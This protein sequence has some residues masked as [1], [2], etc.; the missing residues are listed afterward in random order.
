MTSYDCGNPIKPIIIFGILF[1]I[2]ILYIL[3]RYRKSHSSES[4]IFQFGIKEKDLGKFVPV[5]QTFIQGLTPLPLKPDCF[6]DITFRPFNVSNPKTDVT[7]YEEGILVRAYKQFYFCP[8]TSCKIEPAKI[9]SEPSTYLF[10]EIQRG[11]DLQEN[12]EKLLAGDYYY[13]YKEVLVG[14]RSGI[15]ADTRHYTK[16]GKLDKRYSKQN[17]NAGGTYSH[18]EYSAT[19]TFYVVSGFA[20][21]VDKGDIQFEIADKQDFL[22]LIKLVYTKAGIPI[23]SFNEMSS[24]EGMVGFQKINVVPLLKEEDRL[25]IKEYLNNPKS[26]ESDDEIII[27]EE[28]LDRIIKDG[29]HTRTVNGVKMGMTREEVRD[30]EIEMR[31]F[32]KEMSEFNEEREGEKLFEGILKARQK[33][34]ALVEEEDIDD[35]DNDDLNIDED[36]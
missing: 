1:I 22:T 26:G 29:N 20:L 23:P 19:E 12:Y 6:S 32:K 30:F 24:Y 21:S 4:R 13:Y 34:L 28:E 11:T 25:K 10:Y 14:H 9:Y 27:S 5:D 3:Y 15:K 2:L 31:K 33:E 7:V 36:I 8:F 17:Q 35:I 16:S 18:R